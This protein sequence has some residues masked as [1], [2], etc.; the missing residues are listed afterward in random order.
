[1]TVKLA[2]LQMV[3]DVVTRLSQ[4][5]FQLKGWSVILIAAL[6]A[7]AAAGTQ[8]LFVYLA[9]FPAFA[10][11][12]LDAYFLRHLGTKVTIQ[13]GKKKGT[14]RLIIDFYSL[15]QFDGLMQRL[16]FVSE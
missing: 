11:W 4:N 2:H 13:G 7:L 5:S 1:M 9:Y 10:F 15:D 14:G 6:F 12:A 3:Q 16:E 8:P